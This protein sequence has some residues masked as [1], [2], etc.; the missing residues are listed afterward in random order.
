MRVWAIAAA[1]EMG[2]TIE[3]IHEMSKIE[4]WSFGIRDE[5]INRTK[6]P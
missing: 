6:D 3:E 5:T 2:L 4:E 1:F